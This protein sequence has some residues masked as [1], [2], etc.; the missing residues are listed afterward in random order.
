MHRVPR[1]EQLDS[2]PQ[3]SQSHE[4][5]IREAKSLV[6]KMH[7][8]L[9]DT[10]ADSI[11]MHRFD[12][13]SKFL[14]VKYFSDKHGDPL[15]ATREAESPKVYAKRIKKFYLQICGEHPDLIPKK[16]RDLNASEL[17][18][19][20]IGKLLQGINP[21]S[22]NMDFFGTAYEEMINGTFDKNENQQFFTPTEVVEFM[23]TLLP[24]DIDGV[25]ADPACG[26]GGFLKSLAANGFHKNRLLGIEIDERLAWISRM[27][28]LLHGHEDFHVDVVPDGGTFSNEAD[29]YRNTFTAILTNP[30]FGS[31]LTDENLLAKF[32]LGLNRV[33]RRRGILFLERCWEFLETDGTLLIILDQGVLNS[34]ATRDVRE[35]LLNRFVVMGIVSLPETAFMPYASVNSSILLLKKSLDPNWSQDTFFAS[36]DFIGRRA[37]GDQDFEFLPNG[38][39]QL[40]SDLLDIQQAYLSGKIGTGSVSNLWYWTDLRENLDANLRMDFLFHHPNRVA[41]K[42]ILE[43]ANTGLVSLSEICEEINERVTPSTDF[44]GE[45]LMYSGLSHIA[46]RT[47]IAHQ[48]PTPAAAI[49]SSVKRY[50][51]G[52]ILFSKMR[53]ALRKVALADFEGGGFVSPEC[54]VLRIKRDEF[55]QPIIP[56]RV[57]SALL[58]SDFVYGQVIHLVTG[59]GRP[60]LSSKDL[61]DIQIPEANLATWNEASKNYDSNLA[62]S[63]TLYFKAEELIQSADHLRAE[64]L[65]NL[66][67]DLGKTF[68]VG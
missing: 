42:L 25:I 66:V 35:F 23:A 63:S 58:R 20:K 4:M 21:S 18:I 28:L 22:L 11:I 29:R 40:K 19:Y 68:D 41:S 6:T 10:D 8:I 3:T 24:S 27:N 36:A 13:L 46:P 45:V 2:N 56:P 5:G 31:D 14:L 33:S 54:S 59:I 49:K 1:L 34:S 48:I 64:A 17:S 32:Q 37:N 16:F 38:Q 9:R 61:L 26:T 7:N 44:Q 15:F 57:L 30:P 53:P 12:E 65:R 39:M 60:R 43:N 62:E 55:G 51:S 52:D 50:Q 67:Q 47:G